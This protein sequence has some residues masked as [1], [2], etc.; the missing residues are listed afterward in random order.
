M[1]DSVDELQKQIAEQE[2]RAE[3]FQRLHVEGMVEH[4][5]RKAAQEAGAFNADQ[6]LPYLKPRGKLVEVDG[7]QV[8][9]IASTNEEGQEILH[10]AAE[11]VG[12]MKRTKDFENFFPT[13]PAPTPAPA[14]PPKLDF[15]NMSQEHYLKIRT[16]HPEWLGLDPL[17]KRHR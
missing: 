10:T 15:K 16:E 11:A 14:G 17:P 6:V 7:K 1:S 9:R 2:T 12:I 13:A 5:L 3:T 4:A 8:V